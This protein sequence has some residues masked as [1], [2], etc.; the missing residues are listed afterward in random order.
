MDRRTFLLH[1][2]AL[3]AGTVTGELRIAAQAG[4]QLQ[5]GHPMAPP[6][7]V[8]AGPAVLEPFA[9]RAAGLVFAFNFTGGRLRFPHVL[10][11][12]VAAPQGLPAS[13]EMS[14]LETS[15]HCTGEDIPDHHG[16]KFTGGSPGIRMTFAG[17]REENTARGKRLILTHR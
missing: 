11:E 15:I 7:A 9:W 6:V 12:G 13:S 17:K 10:P 8:E 3:A 5:S 2:A 16:A 4:D 14:S 1:S